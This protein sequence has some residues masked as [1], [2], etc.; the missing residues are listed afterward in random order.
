M[1][2]IQRGIIAAVAPLTSSNSW[3]DALSVSLVGLFNQ[4]SGI[5]PA[6]SHFKE[7]AA[8]LFSLVAKKI[9]RL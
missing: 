4:V 5:R 3:F 7:R 6:V 1:R 8:G 2:F 9:M